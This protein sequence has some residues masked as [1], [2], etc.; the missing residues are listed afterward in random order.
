MEEQ[1]ERMIRT[2]GIVSR[3]RREDIA[4]VVPP[5][6]EWLADHGVKVLCDEETTGASHTLT[7]TPREHLPALADL[8]I[9]LGGDGTLLAAARLLGEGERN[10]TT[11]TR[12]SNWPSTARRD[13]ASACSSIRR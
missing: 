6:L 8:L 11:S 5:L 7:A 12:C 2:V 1:R 3:P 4:S 9:V 10:V 13:T